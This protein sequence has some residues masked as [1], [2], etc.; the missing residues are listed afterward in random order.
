MHHVFL[1]Y[2]RADAAW[3]R[4]L[5][6]RLASAGH[7]VWLDQADIPVTVPWMREVQDAI[8]EAA[9]FL[10]CDS[11]AFRQSDNC[12]AETSLAGQAGKPQFVVTV[13]SDP[14]ACAA[15]VG[16]TMRQISPARGQRTELRVLSRDWDRAGRP[17]NRLVSSAQR[18]RL[19]RGLTVPPPAGETEVSFLRS[20]RSRARR[21]AAIAAATAVLTFLSITAT[22][23]FK[24]AQDRINTDNSSQAAAYATERDGLSLV[25]QDPYS[26]LSLAAADGG[27]EADVHAAVISAALAEATPD[28]SFT[29]PGARRFTVRPVGTDVIVTGTRG[30]E[31]HRATAAHGIRSA[32][33]LRPPV[34]VSAAP[35]PGQLTAAPRPHSGEVGI[36]R[37]GRLWRTVTFDGPPQALAFS[38]DGRFLAAAIG[39]QAEIADLLT[40]QIRQQLRGAPGPLL[41]VAWSSDGGHIWAL[42][43]RRALA[44]PT[45]D[46]ATLVDEPAASYNSVLPAA[47]PHAVWVVG[48]HLLTEINAATGARLAQRRVSDTIESAGAAPDGSVALVSGTGR[49]WVV[50]LA[51]PGRARPVNLPGCVLGRPTFGD[52]STAYVPCIG[53]ALL[54]LAMPAGRVTA[55]VNLSPAGVFGVQAVPGT[56]LVYAGDQAG[57]VYLVRGP[58]VTRLWASECDADLSRIGV[59]PGGRAVLPVGSGSGL[60]TC[61]RV[62]TLGPGDPASPAS[63]TWNAVAEGQ[64][65]SIVATAVSFNR[66][67]DGFAIGYSNGTITFHPT[68]NITP[69]LTVNTAAGMVRDMLMLKDGDLIAVT[70]AGMVQRMPFCDGCL[71]DAALSR[72]AAARLALAARLG[73]ARRMSSHGAKG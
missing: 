58:R 68:R 46:A 64:Q 57:Y 59:A 38:P 14:A 41:D 22:L 66:F 3:V 70:S 1:S 63:W 19:G 28:D 27:D 24:G 36:R 16:R 45:G 73:L 9:L 5:A 67:G 11:P 37:A 54:T 35:V 48:A 42:T 71:S 49:L 72:V 30:R 43:A 31:W 34:P 44:W 26:G 61:T 10:R 62:G 13:G 20:S 33:R 7:R 52:D 32:A 15:D 4:D 8:E 56:S 18:R 29:V 23:V 60:G 25:A 69:T 65:S 53:G 17:R 51:G 55:R 6:D 21:R 12:S 2:S 40:G 47:D 39:W 50:P